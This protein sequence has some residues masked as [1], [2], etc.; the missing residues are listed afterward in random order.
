LAV[1][2]EYPP[3]EISVFNPFSEM[4]VTLNFIGQNNLNKNILKYSEL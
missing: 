3:K 4:E 1:I 2:K